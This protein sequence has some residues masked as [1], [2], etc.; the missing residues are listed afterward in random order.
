MLHDTIRYAMLCYAMIYAM[1]ARTSHFTS[2]IRP[3]PPEKQASSTITVYTSRLVRVILAQG[4]CWSSLHRSKSNR[5]SPKGI[6]NMYVC[7][8][9][10]MYVC[11]YLSLSLYIYIHT[12]IHIPTYTYIHVYA[13][14]CMYVY[15]YIYRERERYISLSLYIYICIHMY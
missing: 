14:V 5:W 11:V 15:I 4:P 6:R 8:H 12:Y 1:C 2:R 13:Y 3:A 9:V 7:M 10:C